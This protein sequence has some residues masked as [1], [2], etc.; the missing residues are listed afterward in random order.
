MKSG[1]IPECRCLPALALRT[2]VVDAGS[3]IEYVS[4]D[5]DSDARSGSLHAGRVPTPSIRNE[6]LIRK[7]C[8]APSLRSGPRP[9]LCCATTKP[10]PKT[11]QAIQN[12][13]HF[14]F[15][16]FPL[17][18]I[19]N[20]P[21]DFEFLRGARSKSVRPKASRLKRISLKACDHFPRLPCRY[22]ES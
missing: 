6:V 16:H 4:D 9:P 17:G 12:E 5:D 2:F 22:S 1:P 13:S 20:Q 18:R 3:G 21:I 8:S 10:A 15:I 19:A 11:E 14:V 7:F